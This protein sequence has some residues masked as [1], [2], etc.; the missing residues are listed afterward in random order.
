MSAKLVPT[1][2]DR[3]CRVVSA[4]DPPGHQSWFSRPGAAF[5]FK[6]LLSYAHEAE[7][8]PFQTHYFSEN[9]VAPGIEPGTS[10]SVARNSDHLTTE[11][12]HVHTIFLIYNSTLIFVD[13]LVYM[14]FWTLIHLSHFLAPCALCL[15][16][17]VASLIHY[18]GKETGTQ[19]QLYYATVSSFSQP[20]QIK[21][22]CK[23]RNSVNLTPSLDT[24]L[25]S[26]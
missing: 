13:H 11:V 23:K 21:T 8:T 9:L 17:F 4:V 14:P 25:F 5:P 12:V 3:G 6:Y 10:G 26:L 15:M 19:H 22:D 1:F 7:W 16:I 2:S 18:C 20:G 24:T